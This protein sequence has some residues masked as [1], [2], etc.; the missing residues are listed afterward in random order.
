MMTATEGRESA[1]FMAESAN[2][3]AELPACQC[4]TEGLVHFRID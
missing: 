4:R 3:M 1:N 2:F